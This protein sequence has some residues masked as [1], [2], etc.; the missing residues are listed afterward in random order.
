MRESDYLLAPG[1]MCLTVG[2][3]LAPFP[4]LGLAGLGLTVVGIGLLIGGG[5]VARSRSVSAGRAAAGLLAV[6]AGAVG[7]A[8]VGLAGAS[9]AHAEALH[10]SRQ[11][12]PPPPKADWAWLAAALPLPPA[13]LAL[14]LWARARRPAFT[15]LIWGLVAAAVPPIGIGLFAAADDVFPL[16]A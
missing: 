9:V 5:V 16:D 3:A 13:V 11:L 15:C 12:G 14:G 6:V 10:A 4:I 7:V 1:L 8:V 2:P